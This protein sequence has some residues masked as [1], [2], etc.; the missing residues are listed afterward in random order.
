MF[1]KP[2]KPAPPR[3][4]ASP[5]RGV[6]VQD[7]RS[8]RIRR[9]MAGLERLS[10]LSLSMARATEREV[11][12][13]IACGDLEA[14][15]RAVAAFDRVADE[16]C[17]TV[18]LEARLEARLAAALKAEA[19]EAVRAPAFRRL[20]PRPAPAEPSATPPPTARSRRLH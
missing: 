14:L 9:L 6:G 8:T 11:A 4:M 16:V 15:D 2:I 17:R 10:E 19:R 18:A 7:L 12:A 3:S 5:T 1:M 13:A 20:S